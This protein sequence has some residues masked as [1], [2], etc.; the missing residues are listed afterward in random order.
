ME[1]GDAPGA[2]PGSRGARDRGAP[3]TRAYCLHA[4]RPFPGQHVSSPGA[5]DL[6]HDSDRKVPARS[7]VL[8]E[9][10]LF[11]VGEKI[12]DFSF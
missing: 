8:T 3:A 5:S 7:T 10:S 11:I 4:L 1:K 9:P 12:Y 6:Q 2:G